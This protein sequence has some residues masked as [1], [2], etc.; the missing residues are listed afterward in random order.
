MAGGGLVNDP[1]NPTEPLPTLP[2][3]LGC[4]ALTGAEAAIPPPAGISWTLCS[5]CP[6]G[7][8][9]P[10]AL[11]D[12]VDALIVS[13][14]P[15]PPV[16]ATGASTGLLLALFCARAKLSRSSSWEETCFIGTLLMGVAALAPA[17]A[18]APPPATPGFFF[19]AFCA[20]SR[21]PARYI[22]LNSSLCASG[23]FD[24]EG[25]EMFDSPPGDKG[26]LPAALARLVVLPTAVAR[27]LP[28]LFAAPTLRGLIPFPV[29]D[30]GL[31][32]PPMPPPPPPFTSMLCSK[33]SIPS[34][35]AASTLCPSS[36]ECNA[37]STLSCNNGERGTESSEM[38][39]VDWTEEQRWKLF[40]MEEAEEE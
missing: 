28:M 2:K 26:P 34:T 25:N 7:L 11:M 24:S 15:I 4:P 3:L 9:T 16:A 35:A 32:T 17:R 12:P 30:K 5:K 21:N 1:A 29:G 22:L 27:K 40:G 13:A 18:P 14:A 36:N 23:K 31:F 10:M 39:M 38:D 19:L 6:R 33:C 37:C 20:A 8:A